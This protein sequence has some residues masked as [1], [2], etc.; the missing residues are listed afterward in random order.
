MIHV[1][2]YITISERFELVKSSR[3]NGRRA[4]RFWMAVVYFNIHY[5]RVNEYF[6]TIATRINQS[7]VAY[8]QT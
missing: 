6:Y 4:L 7:M 8:V 1:F 5:A 3:K 2:I